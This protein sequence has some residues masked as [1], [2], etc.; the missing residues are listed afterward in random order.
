MSVLRG[1]LKDS[2][3]YYQRLERDLKRRLA[4]LPSGSVKRRRLKGRVYYYLQQRRGHKVVHRYLGRE[5]PVELIRA[6]EERRLL[7]RELVKVEAALRLI[8]ARK[9]AP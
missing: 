2:L 7:R 6:I 9:I 8:P 5:K 4:H 1:I 3:R